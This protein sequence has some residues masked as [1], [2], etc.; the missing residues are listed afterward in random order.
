METHVRNVGLALLTLGILFA[1][2]SLSVLYAFGGLDGVMMTNDPFYKRKDIG[3]IPLERLLGVVYLILSL[4]LSG[5]MVLTGWGI[6][7]WSPWAKTVGLLLSAVILL[8]FPIGSGLGVY[9]LWVLTDESTE[10][11]FANAPAGGARR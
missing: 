6:L 2:V 1:V 3:S 4:A 8:H 10:F 11:L 5:P 9:S 7:R